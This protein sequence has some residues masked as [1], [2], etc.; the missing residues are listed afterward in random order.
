MYSAQWL[1]ENHPYWLG[2]VTVR[3]DALALSIQQKI[4]QMGQVNRRQL[5]AA[6]VIGFRQIKPAAAS[7]PGQAQ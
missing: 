4:N 7:G 6:D 5:P 2:N 1:R 3:Y